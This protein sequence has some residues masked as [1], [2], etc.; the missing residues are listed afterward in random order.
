[1]V[2]IELLLQLEYD[3]KEEKNTL[4]ILEMK[5]LIILWP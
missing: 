5:N 3:L 2:T 4:I 1:M